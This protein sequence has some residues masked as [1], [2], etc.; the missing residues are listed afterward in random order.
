MEFIFFLMFVFS[1]ILALGL[2]LINQV[3]MFQLNSYKPNVHFDWIKK[4]KNTLIIKLIPLLLTIPFVGFLSEIGYVLS[5][6]L[7]LFV[8]YINKPKKAK[9]AL[10]YTP[11]VKRMITTFG[12]LTF[13]NLVAVYFNM[14]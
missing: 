6:L 3:H 1:S 7:Y 13:L 2:V 4:N 12:I 8:A 14:D 11:R 9:K 10:V 5:A